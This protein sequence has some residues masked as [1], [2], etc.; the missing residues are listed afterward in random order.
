MGDWG[1][2][3]GM[4]IAYMKI[5]YPKFLEE[6]IEL[7]DLTTFYKES[8]KLFDEDAE[9]KKTAQLTVVDL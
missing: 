7:S 6:E 2:Q 4:L 1:T 5:K 9:F 3:F 8:K